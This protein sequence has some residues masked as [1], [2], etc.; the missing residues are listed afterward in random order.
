MMPATL[1]EL[2]RVGYILRGVAACLLVAGIAQAEHAS[3]VVSA[4]SA[5]AMFVAAGGLVATGRTLRRMAIRD[6]LRQERFRRQTG[7]QR[8]AD[9]QRY[10]PGQGWV[11]MRPRKV[12]R[13]V[14]LRD[15]SDE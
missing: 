2:R 6:E 10:T 9:A 5:A 13:G 3:D 8:L 15:G 12:I 4:L 1:D 14:T 7:A 11:Y